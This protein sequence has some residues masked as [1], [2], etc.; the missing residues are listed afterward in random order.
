MKK[1]KKEQTKR[2]KQNIKHKKVE[3][4]NRK[5]NKKQI[6]ICQLNMADYTIKSSWLELKA[7]NSFTLINN[8]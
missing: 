5:E 7:K 2:N 1:R 4:E 8:I 3:S 6:K